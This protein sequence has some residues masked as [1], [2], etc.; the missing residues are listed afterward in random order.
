MHC[1][2][3]KQ[4]YLSAL[5][6]VTVNQPRANHGASA[7]LEQSSSNAVYSPTLHRR[8][9]PTKK[10]FVSLISTFPS[11]T[12]NSDDVFGVGRHPLP[13]VGRVIQHVPGFRRETLDTANNGRPNKSHRE[14]LLTAGTGRCGRL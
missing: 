7:S 3:G 12:V 14:V 5:K 11:F 8:S 9:Q 10:Y 13:H 2:C 4:T 6:L 1:T